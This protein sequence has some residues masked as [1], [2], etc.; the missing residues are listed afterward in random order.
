M[1]EHEVWIKIS[2]INF[3]TWDMSKY[4]DTK[5]TRRLSTL[6]SVRKLR[7]LAARHVIVQSHSMQFIHLPVSIPNN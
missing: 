2:T 5:Y 3:Q 7:T 6:S 4:Y 1:K